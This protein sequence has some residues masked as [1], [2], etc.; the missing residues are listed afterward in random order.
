M[1]GGSD[2]RSTLLSLF[3]AP[4]VLPVLVIHFPVC[5]PIYPILEIPL[6]LF[7]SISDSHEALKLIHPVNQVLC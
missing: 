7:V 3:F 1:A 6:L 2:D 4:D 5:R